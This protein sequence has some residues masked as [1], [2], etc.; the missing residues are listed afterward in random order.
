LGAQ[1]LSHRTTR[2]VPDE[3]FLNLLMSQD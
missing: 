2:E 3:D 1:S